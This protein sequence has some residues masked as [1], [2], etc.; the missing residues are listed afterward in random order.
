MR[1]P[2]SSTRSL[3]HGQVIYFYE[4]NALISYTFNPLCDATIRA[5]TYAAKI[6]KEKCKSYKISNLDLGDLSTYMEQ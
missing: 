3:A 2:L 1:T 6:C 4:L 5:H